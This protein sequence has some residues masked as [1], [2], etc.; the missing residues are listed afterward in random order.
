VGLA[1]SVGERTDDL[2]VVH[3]EDDRVLVVNLMSKEGWLRLG[4]NPMTQ[5]EDQ[6]EGGEED[7][8]PHGIVLSRLNRAWWRRREDRMGLGAEDDLCALAAW[9]IDCCSAPAWPGIVDIDVMGS[10]FLPSDHLPG[11]GGNG[12]EG[13]QSQESAASQHGGLLEVGGVHAPGEV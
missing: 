7:D 12:C 9:A 5:S 11:N 8:E 13:K 1:L 2:V 4:P 10:S 3:D 6:P